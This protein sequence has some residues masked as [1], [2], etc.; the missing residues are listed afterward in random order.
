[1]LM[2][3]SCLHVCILCSFV[4][5]QSRNVDFNLSAKT[6]PTNHSKL[7][8]CEILIQLP[9]MGDVD[10]SKKHMYVLPINSLYIVERNAFILVKYIT[11]INLNL[12]SKP[13]KRNRILK[14]I[15]KCN[16]F[17]CYEHLNLYL[18]SNPLLAMVRTNNLIGEHIY[19]L[20][21][22]HIVPVCG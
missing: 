2:S 21:E 5:E 8:D 13:I 12:T 19:L 9:L 1:M 14:R 10:V 4:V 15:K 18:F 7:Q 6:F 17:K 11:N 3:G 16:F 22:V 20:V